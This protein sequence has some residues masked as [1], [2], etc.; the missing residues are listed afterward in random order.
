[1][2]P[3]VAERRRGAP[4]R[5]V[6]GTRVRK[7]L[8]CGGHQEY[9]ARGRRRIGMAGKKSAKL[10]SRKIKRRRRQIF[11]P[12]TERRLQI[13]KGIFFLPNEQLLDERDEQIEPRGAERCEDK[14]RKCAC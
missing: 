10:G 7:K 12:S 4:E 2:K 5:E 13:T 14:E 8:V 3:T 6:R 9:Q 1:M 11:L